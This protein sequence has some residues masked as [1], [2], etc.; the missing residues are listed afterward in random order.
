MDRGRED[1]IGHALN[2]IFITFFWNQTHH[3]VAAVQALRLLVT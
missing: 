1:Y 2:V 3:M